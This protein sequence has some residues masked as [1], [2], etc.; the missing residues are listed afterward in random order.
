[1]LHD[2][3]SGSERVIVTRQSF[4]AIDGPIEFLAPVFSPDEKR[5][6]FTVRTSTGE[7]VW[8]SPLSG[9]VPVALGETEG[10]HY[11][12]AWSPDGSW[13]AYRYNRA[14]GSTALRKIRVGAGENPLELGDYPCRPLWSPTGEWILCMENPPTQPPRLI[15]PDGKRVQQFPQGYTRPA[16]W[17][18]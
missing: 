12:P 8:I 14:N 17:S 9:G 18:A 16:A 1:M 11:S 3:V 6:A 2:R 10:D 15:S 7:G 13:I 5:I 4:P